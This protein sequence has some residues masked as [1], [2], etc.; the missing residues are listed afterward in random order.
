M[1]CRWWLLVTCLD[2]QSSAIDHCLARPLSSQPTRTQHGTTAILLFFPESFCNELRSVAV[3]PVLDFHGLIPP[4]ARIPEQGR[5]YH[6][7]LAFT[8]LYNCFPALPSSGRNGLFSS[9]WRTALFT[10]PTPITS[11]SA[12]DGAGMGRGS[13]GTTGTTRWNRFHRVVQIMEIGT[14]RAIKQAKSTSQAFREHG[15]PTWPSG[16]VRVSRRERVFEM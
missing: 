4:N 16:S 15:I 6:I 8:F 7:R 13:F 5:L 14:D 12:S 3:S 1:L 2:A 10:K 9:L 11:F